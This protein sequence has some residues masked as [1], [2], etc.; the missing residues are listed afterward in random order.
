MEAD[1]AAA[2][3]VDRRPEALQDPVGPV[4]LQAAARGTSLT[5]DMAT[6]HG[7]LTGIVTTIP[8][9]STFK[10]S[11]QL[12]RLM[13]LARISAANVEASHSIL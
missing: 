9:V 10:K 11:N 2:P 12:T 5:L 8:I 1:R 7:I 3:A 13:L 6:L 4:G